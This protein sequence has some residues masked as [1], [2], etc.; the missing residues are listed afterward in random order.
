METFLILAVII[1]QTILTAIVASFF[2]PKRS[3]DDVTADHFGDYPH[4]QE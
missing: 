2:E 1:V 3:I 4:V